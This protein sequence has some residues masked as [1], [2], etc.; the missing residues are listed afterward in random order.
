MTSAY[1]NLSSLITITW[2]KKKSQR[3]E[4]SHFCPP[5]SS[6]SS[7]SQSHLDHCAPSLFISHLNEP[8]PGIP[9]AAAMKDKRL[10]WN[11]KSWTQIHWVQLRLGCFPDHSRPVI[12]S[13]GAPSIFPLLMTSSSVRSLLQQGVS[14]EA[15][16]QQDASH[17]LRLRHPG[18]QGRRHSG[19]GEKATL[20]RGACQQRATGV[21]VLSLQKIKGCLCSVTYI[22]SSNMQDKKVVASAP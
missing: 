3:K 19:P 2:S 10:W 11:F 15:A 22:N 12:T 9:A 5:P 21:C 13:A 18:I 4:I 14:Q 7:S 8:P 1:S 6:S 17:H 16:G 20:Q